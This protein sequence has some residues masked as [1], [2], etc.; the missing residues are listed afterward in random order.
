MDGK[1]IVLSLTRA[2]L[3]SWAVVVPAK[4]SRANSALAAS[5]SSSTLLSRGVAVLVLGI[6]LDSTSSAANAHDCDPFAHTGLISP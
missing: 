2:A 4:P 6:A 5:S 1:K 3:T